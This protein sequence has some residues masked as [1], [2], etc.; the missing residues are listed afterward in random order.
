M[1]ESKPTPKSQAA[2]FVGGLR[3]LSHDRGKLAALRRGLVDNPRL[4]VDAYP[5]V[6]NLGGDIDNP[7]F[8]AIAAL[9]AT[10]SEEASFRNFGETC[11][12][13]AKADTKDIAESTER[14][15][16]RLL[17]SG[18]LDEVI[19]QLRSWIRLAA[20]K[21]VPVNYESLFADLWNWRF[22]SEDI[23]IQ[24]AKAFWQAGESADETAQIT[25]EPSTA[26]AP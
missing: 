26:P 1:S 5:I 13:I 18:N 15:F 14:R 8:T 22:Y 24:W 7:V 19:G 9:Y 12:R 2:H 11:R 23:R 21:G 3:R 20:S 16:R 4:H 10:H 17:A 25:S 6:S